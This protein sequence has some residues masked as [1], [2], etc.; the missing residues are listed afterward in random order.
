MARLHLFDLDNTLLHGTSAPVELSRQLGLEAETVALDREVS[1]GLIEPPEYATRVHALWA[2][3]T[4]APVAAAFE[5]AP[6]LAP[7]PCRSLSPSTRQEFSAPRPRS[8]S[9]TGSARGSV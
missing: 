4:K 7:Q 5:G 9:P 6:W 8:G 3:L 1:A 2:D